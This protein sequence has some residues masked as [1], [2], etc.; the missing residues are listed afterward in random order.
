MAD[1]IEASSAAGGWA[2][3]RGDLWLGSLA[4]RVHGAGTATLLLHGFMGSNRYWGAA[5]DR[6]ADGGLVLAPDLLG[7]GDSP[8]PE[9]GYGPDDHG[10]ALINSLTELEVGGPM[11]VVGHSTGALLALWLASRYPDR[12]SRVVAI[13]PPLF[14]DQ[15]HARRQ[16]RRLGRLE[17]L[18]AFQDWASMI[19]CKTLCQKRPH[20]AT[21]LY[22][23][24]RPEFP[25]PILQDAT[26]HS[27]ISYSE[28][29]KKV[30]LAAE[31]S[32]WLASTS[33][34]VDLIAGT[35]DNLMDL[36]Y[37]RE[38]SAR[39]SQV[40]LRIIPG[41]DHQLPLT[42]PEECLAVIEDLPG[43]APE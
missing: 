11:L 21:R 37:L 25:Y 19:F 2:E 33:R 30:I 28:T 9:R 29:I 38:L 1:P 23:R 26:R 35:E 16:V 27:W 32:Q 40:R 12:V 14:R 7:F 20:L 15:Q 3:P 41:A 34:P 17:R 31:A 8:R 5:Y 10:G 42:R 36:G 13:S 43:D 6:L 22:A 18:F 4:V 39:Y 24:I